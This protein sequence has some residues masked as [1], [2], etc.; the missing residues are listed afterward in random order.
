MSTIGERIALIIKEK[1]ITKLKFAA[2]VGISSGN[3]T[4]LCHDK[5]R[6]SSATIKSICRAYNVNECG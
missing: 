2:V 1:R 3:V 6:P 4:M 5:V